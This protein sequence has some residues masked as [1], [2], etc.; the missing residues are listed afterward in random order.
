MGYKQVVSTGFESVFP[1]TKTANI[2]GFGYFKVQKK[3]RKMLFQYREGEYTVGSG[4]VA[5]IIG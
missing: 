3:R 4:K 5:R 1:Y 2:C